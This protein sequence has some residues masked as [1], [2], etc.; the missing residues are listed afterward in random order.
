MKIRCS[1]CGTYID[2]TLATC[3]NCGAP[4]E[5]V[6]RTTSKQPLTIGELKQWYQDRGLPPA[7]TTRFFIG[8]DYK[9]P[10]AFGIYKDEKT[11][12]CVVYKNKANGERAVRYQGTD[13]AY[14]VNELYQR[15]KQEIIE[16]KNRAAGKDGAYRSGTGDG[17]GPK[18]GKTF[19]FGIMGAVISTIV[20]GVSTIFGFVS[21]DAPAAGYYL[22]EDTP[23][24]YATESGSSMYDGWFAYELGDWYGLIRSDY[25]PEALR[26]NKTAKEYYVSRDWEIGLPCT[27]F[28]D[29]IEYQDLL[30]HFEVETGYYQH[31]GNTYYHVDDAAELGWYTYDAGS[32]DWHEVNYGDLPEEL[33]HQT[34]AE[35]FYYTPDWDSDTQIKDFEDTEYYREHEENRNSDSG[36]EN[37]DNDSDYDW[38]SGDSWDSGGSD[39]DSDW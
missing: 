21:G 30:N 15:L 1:Y 13:E 8:E 12:N 6:V 29:S 28:R 9:G 39:W 26:E 7:E 33:S 31:N 2:D 3:P 23:Y 38:D 25:M 16:Q 19:I 36:W 5:G 17:D 11:G 14:A 20:I 27:D 37:S 10:R 18:K 34:T 24:Y 35:D 22:Y 4:N 32:D